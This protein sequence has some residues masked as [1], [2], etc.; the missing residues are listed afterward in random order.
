MQPAKGAL[1][2]EEHLK[3]NPVKKVKGKHG[4]PIHWNGP[5]VMFMAPIAETPNVATA[6]ERQW[7]TC[8]VG[9]SRRR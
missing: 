5:S 7:F 2:P 4:E 9:V 3:R 1:T 6:S 8:Y